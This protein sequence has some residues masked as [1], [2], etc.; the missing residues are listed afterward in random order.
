MPRGTEAARWEALQLSRMRGMVQGR[1]VRTIRERSGLSLKE[2]ADACGVTPSCV[3]YW[4]KGEHLPQGEPAV[5][6]ARLLFDL[7][8]LTRR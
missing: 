2:V 5:R 1:T 7:E 8:D 6:Y 3:H 4:E